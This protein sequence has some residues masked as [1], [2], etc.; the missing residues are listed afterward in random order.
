LAAH[1]VLRLCEVAKDEQ[2]LQAA[3]LVGKRGLAV[4]SI[5]FLACLLCDPV[6]HE[7]A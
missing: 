7:R 2:L 5:A 3:Q 4:R 1:D 6:E